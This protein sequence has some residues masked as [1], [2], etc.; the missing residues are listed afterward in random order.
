MKKEILYEKIADI[1]EIPQDAVIDGLELQD[2]YWDSLAIMAVIAAIDETYDV[3]VPSAQ[4][5]DCKTVGD[6]L[7]VIESELNKTQEED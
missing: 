5:L 3:T 2:D 4:L 1:L 6:I 7:I